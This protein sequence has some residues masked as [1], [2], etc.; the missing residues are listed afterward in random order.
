MVVAH[1]DQLRVHRGGLERSSLS[2]LVCFGG[3]GPGEVT[4]HGQKVVGVSQRRTREMAR[5]QCVVH[6]RWSPELYRRYIL[7]DKIKLSES[8]INVSL[9]TEISRIAVAEVAGLSQIAETI[10]ELAGKL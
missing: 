3:L 7:T 1:R 8:D 5:F 4:L 2:D 6:Q 10:V 9:E